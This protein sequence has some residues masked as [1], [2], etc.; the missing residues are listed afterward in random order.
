[1]IARASPAFPAPAPRPAP[2][3]R[4]ASG[5]GFPTP[6]CR[7]PPRPGDAAAATRPGRRQGCRLGS[8]RFAP[9]ERGRGRETGKGRRLPGLCHA[10]PMTILEGSKDSNAL[11][12]FSL[13]RAPRHPGA[14]RH[15]GR[16]SGSG[17]RVLPA[18]PRLRSR[19]ASRPRAKP[20][21]P[22]IPRA[23]RRS[24]P[25][26]QP[27][28]LVP[29]HRARA[30]VDLAARGVAA[31]P[32]ALHAPPRPADPSRSSPAPARLKRNLRAQSM[33]AP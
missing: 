8:A 1:M 28:Y 15:L 31:S 33:P 16:L 12:S 22:A 10:A 5:T 17:A 3:S 19:G 32:Y 21:R 23:M 29:R 13:D 24:P 11:P 25:L 18:C 20:R 26:R 9:P 30:F 6:R 7:C 4:A 14:V 2:A 27:S